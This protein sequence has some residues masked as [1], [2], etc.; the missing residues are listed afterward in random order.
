[1]LI[2]KTYAFEVKP[3]PIDRSPT[4]RRLIR[5]AADM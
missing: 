5:L 1:M 4:A 2:G 3:G